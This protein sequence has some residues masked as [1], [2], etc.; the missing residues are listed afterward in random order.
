MI[1]RMYTQ[2]LLVK[3]SLLMA[4]VF[5]LL[6]ALVLTC[7]RALTGEVATEHTAYSMAERYLILLVLPITVQLWADVED[8]RSELFMAMPFSRAEILV[9]RL[10]WP[11]AAY[12]AITMAVLLYADRYI[13]EISGVQMYTIVA[14]SLP[15]ALALLAAATLLSVA[16]KN[17]IAGGAA[18]FAWWLMEFITGGRLTKQFYLFAAT[19]AP[20]KLNLTANRWEL[21]AVAAAL[22]LAAWLFYAQ[23]ERFIGD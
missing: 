6:C 22:V 5:G 1:K 16:A 11:M 4:A 15:A 9:Y 17:G 20:V 2:L 21:V 12:A 23:N 7:Y 14:N 3:Q 19:A 8:K 18:G 13:V 10:F